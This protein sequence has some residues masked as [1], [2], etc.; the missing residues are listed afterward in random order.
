MEQ[1]VAVLSKMEPQPS[2]ILY[3]WGSE[4]ILSAAFARASS[5]VLI[6]QRVARFL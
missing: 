2:Q 4:A 3:L 5:N 6:L 1:I